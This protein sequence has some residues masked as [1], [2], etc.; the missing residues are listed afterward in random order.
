M[1]SAQPP[2]PLSERYSIVDLFAGPGGLDVAASWLGIDTVG[3]EKDPN[4]RMTRVKAGFDKDLALHD[5]DRHDVEK[6]DP[7]GPEFLERNVLVGGPPCQTFSV[8]GA[9]S[10]RRLLHEVCQAI[11]QIGANPDSD[12]NKSVKEAGEE[13]DARTRLV[14]QP[15]RWILRKMQEEKPY[16]VIVLEQVPAVRPIWEA[17]A[18]VLES[19][20]YGYKVDVGVLRTEEFGVPQTRRRAILIANLNRKIKLPTPTHQPY[21][22]DVPPLED[23]PGLPKA[24]VSMAAALPD[25]AKLGKFTVRSNYGTGG[26]P[27]ARGQRDSSLPAFTVTGKVS[28]NLLSGEGAR[29]AGKDRFTLNEMGALQSFPADFPWYDVDAAQQIG[30]AIPPRLAAHVLAA[31]LGGTVNSDDLNKAVRESWNKTKWVLSED[32]RRKKPA[33]RLKEQFPQPFPPTS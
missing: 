28:R 33:V 24:W 23:I 12:I 31:A 14:L 6:N 11:K 32:N 5:L 1:T 16:D 9:G 20:Q 4:A 21:R 19:S 13:L 25:R 15:L 7:C 8:A 2:A 27:K 18:E 22:K 3:V 26:D 30:N 10:G 29:G 17:L